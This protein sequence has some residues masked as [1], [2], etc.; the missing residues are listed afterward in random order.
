MVWPHL[1]ILGHVEDNS[2]GESERS[3]ETK[4][5]KEMGKIHQG[6]HGNGVW[7]FPEG[8]G[9]Q[10]RVY[11][12]CCNFICGAPTTSEVKGLILDEMRRHVERLAGDVLDPTGQMGH[13][14]FFFLVNITRMWPP[15]SHQ[16]LY[17]LA[18]LIIRIFPS[19]FM[20]STR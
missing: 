19:P 17:G 16:A 4:T 8:S 1:K 13:N 14:K 5:E 6:K 7:R 11:R 20:P 12:Y 2:A 3:K 18:R 15:W 9:R 10:G